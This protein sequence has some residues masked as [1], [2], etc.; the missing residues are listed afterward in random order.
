MSKTTFTEDLENNRL[1]AVRKFEAPVEKVWKAWSNP[2]ILCQWWAPS[3]YRCTID[4]MI[5][6]EG[7]YWIYNMEGP[8]GDAY[9]G[10]MDFLKMQEHSGFKAEEYFCDENG[11]K[12]GDI[13]PMHLDVKFEFKDSATIVTATYT[14]ASAEA[15]Q[16]MVQMGAAEGWELSMGQLEEL[17]MA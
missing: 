14:Y 4:E 5:F 1:V 15:F 13:P 17:L 12:A 9:R 7:G 2:D 3:P 8:E 6:E 16:Q 10:R 11:D